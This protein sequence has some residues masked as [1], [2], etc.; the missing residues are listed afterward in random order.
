MSEVAHTPTSTTLVTIRV[1]VAMKERF[2]RLV[3]TLGA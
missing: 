1:P 2:E 3:L